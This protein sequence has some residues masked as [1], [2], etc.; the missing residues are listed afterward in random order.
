MSTLLKDRLRG[1]AKAGCA[2]G[3]HWTGLDQIVGAR[4]GLKEA[5]LVV[6]YHRVVEDFQRS[7]RLSI[8]PM[9]TSASTFEK[10]LDWIGKRY[11]FVSLDEL[12]LIFEGAEKRSKPVAAITFDDGYQDVYCNAFPI[13]KRKG[14]PSA[15]FVV[16]DLV[17]TERLLAHDELHLLLSAVV[18]EG[19]ASGRDYWW[20]VVSSF[21]LDAEQSRLLY[22]RINN[23]DNPFQATRAVLETLGRSDI[24]SVIQSLSKQNPIPEQQLKDFQILNWDML[25][26][27]AADGVTIG[28]H[29]KSHVLLANETADVV[30]DEVEGSRREL[31]QRLG[32]PIEHFA[33]PDG[34]FN[35]DAIAAVASAGYRTAHTVCGHRDPDNPLL[36]IPRKMLWQNSCMDGFGRFSP[37]ILSCQVNG[38]F[39]PSDRCQRRHLA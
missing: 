21:D 37:S 39:D 31:E 7:D 36:S 10:H 26:E 38:I 29:T 27:M 14:I 1:M 24:N 34:S 9:L 25:R 32:M 28:S 33:Y 3:V 8:A 19:K 11:D 12:S 4:R 18:A 16:T 6:G 17:G 22:S 13:L 20:N 23:V 5:P 35:A 15:V 30:R 2:A